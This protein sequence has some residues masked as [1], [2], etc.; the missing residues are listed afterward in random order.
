MTATLDHVTRDL[1]APGGPGGPKGLVEGVLQW[2]PGTGAIHPY[3]SQFVTNSRIIRGEREEAID[4]LYSFLLHTT[5]THGFPEGVYYRRREGWGGTIPHLWAAALYV[6]TLRNALL[7]EDGRDLHLLS[8]VPAAWLEPG[9]RIALEGAP[10]RFGPAGFR[11]EGGEGTIRLS[12]DPPARTPPA[13]VVVHAPA[14]LRIVS[15]ARAGEAPAVGGE[16]AVEGGVRAVLSG[17]GARSPA[18][19]LLR[20]ERA[21]PAPRTFEERAREMAAAAPPALR[22][23]PGV[24]PGPPA[25]IDRSACIPLDLSAAATTDP[26]SAPFLVKNAP[27]FTGPPRRRP[28]G[29]RGP[30]PPPRPR[31]E[32]GPGAG[33]PPGRRGLRGAAAI[34][35][36]PRRR[37]R[38]LARGAG[39][40][41]GVGAG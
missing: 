36:G 14:G 12:V 28:P 9:K 34:G 30:L 2:R 13:R 20:V 16:I 39:E 10:T 37:D 21:G 33:G 27:A 8:A 32:R 35:G 5:S 26:R 11:A 15:A 23:V 1:S 31:G 24:L 18:D 38:P 41:D 4:G 25:G 22:P 17:T 6:T 7:R 3:L 19:L 40:R 29:G